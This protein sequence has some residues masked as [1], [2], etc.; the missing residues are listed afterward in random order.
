M[1]QT[2]RTPFLHDVV[3]SRALEAILVV[4]GAL[5]VPFSTAGLTALIEAALAAA[6]LGVELVLARRERPAAGPSRV[7][8]VLRIAVPGTLAA[9]LLAFA[10]A[11]WLF[12]AATVR[13]VVNRVEA[14]CGAALS[15]ASVTGSLWSGDL[16]FTGFVAR[17]TEGT[18]HADLRVA[19]LRVDVAM[20]GALVGNASFERIELEGARGEIEHAAG[21]E[22]REGRGALDTA[23]AALQRRVVADSVLVKDIVVRV[24]DRRDEKLPFDAELEVESL[25][26]RPLHGAFVWFDLLFR[27]TAKGSLDGA[28]FT[29]A[30]EG[31]GAGRRTR[32]SAKGL[33]VKHALPYCAWLRPFLAGGELDVEADDTWSLGEGVVIHTRWYVTLRD[34]K[35]RLRGGAGTPAERKLFEL[36]N[37]SRG[38]LR[39]ELGLD[40]REGDF[41]GH[42]SLATLP[43]L[44]AIGNLVAEQL[45]MRADLDAAELKALH[46]TVRDAWKNAYDTWSRR[47]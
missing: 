42:A 27:T 9:S 44:A 13:F 2:G 11:D 47:R 32:W 20:L 18:L 3:D 6:Q 29:I 26:T 14:R 4:F 15:Y 41:E 31:D 5:L 28:P 46:A 19:K 30:T 45:G 21:A 7:R 25:E 36:L 37:G 33:R 23:L 10:L 43:M 40:V 22:R 35:A 39:L 34:P 8:R 1:K 17:R 16:T 24:R 38:S 12:F